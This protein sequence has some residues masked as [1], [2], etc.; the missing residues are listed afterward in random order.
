MVA[1]VAGELETVA[2][3]LAGVLVL[4]VAPV[5]AGVL[6]LPVAPVLAGV[7]VLPVAPVLAVVLGLGAGAVARPAATQSRAKVVASRMV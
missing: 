7:L 1:L 4:P 5:L 6:V 3:V 2:P